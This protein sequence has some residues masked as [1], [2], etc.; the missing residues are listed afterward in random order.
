MPTQAATSESRKSAASPNAM[1]I[2]VVDNWL[3]FECPNCQQTI[4][5]DRKDCVYEIECPSCES[6][7][8]PLLSR[9]TKLPPRRGPARK[10]KRLRRS[11]VNLKPV[12][13]GKQYVQSDEEEDEEPQNPS[14]PTSES[15]PSE[16][17]VSLPLV[18]TRR[19]Q[20]VNEEGA[21]SKLPVRSALELE[22]RRVEATK[23]AHL[24]EQQDESELDAVIEEQSGG[25]YK[26]IR[27]RT[28]KKRQ[29]EKQRAVRLYAYTGIAAMMITGIGLFAAAKRFE[30]DSDD[31]ETSPEVAAQFTDDRPTGQS[32]GTWK[33]LINNFLNAEKVDDVFPLIRKPKRLEAAVRDYYSDGMPKYLARVRENNKSRE[34][35]PNNFRKLLVTIDG[36]QRDL[37]VEKTKSH[38][39][40]VDWESFVGHGSVGWKE[41][42]DARATKTVRLRAYVTDAD[43]Y[44]TP[45]TEKRF[46]CLKLEDPTRRH[47]L[48]GYF[49]RDTA[50]A[51]TRRLIQYFLAAT[52]DLRNVPSEA[53]Q[54]NRNLELKLILDV[55]YP[56]GAENPAQVEIVN[57]EHHSWL[58][59]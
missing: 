23:D 47:T 49:E 40:R 51:N 31:V 37:Y 28:R 54:D 42:I 59:P 20:Y 10:R 27:V 19:G 52:T 8:E 7:F 17:V 38:G 13:P 57:Y 29:T 50:D 11:P 26:R 30:T 22:R 18:E 32:I 45:F 35:L 44:E 12:E 34:V 24:H 58:L 4:K 15:L 53:G 55:R 9:G 41:F 6:G 43:Y 46:R 2:M 3:V 33:V 48:Y 56:P 36:N 14:K 16:G 21:T 39:Y 1:D 5:I 25:K